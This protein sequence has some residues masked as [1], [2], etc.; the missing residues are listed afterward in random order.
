MLCAVQCYQQDQA[1]V[2][3]ALSAFKSKTLPP[4]FLPT[5]FRHK[6]YFFHSTS[7]L[8]SSIPNNQTNSHPTSQ[9]SPLSTY[10]QLLSILRV[11]QTIKMKSSMMITVG[12][13]AISALAQAPSDLPSC[14][15]SS[16]PILPQQLWISREAS[17]PSA[18]AAL[19]LQWLGLLQRHVYMSM[20]ELKTNG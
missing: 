6:D 7:T 4:R 12:A 1:I 10:N 13:F 3:L 5:S 2:T 15:V 14:G 9:P 19:E 18:T 16:F 11:P 20:C 8:P 17:S